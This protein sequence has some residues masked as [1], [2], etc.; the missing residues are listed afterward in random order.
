[1]AEPPQTAFSDNKREITEN[2]SWIQLQLRHQPRVSTSTL[3]P[4]VSIPTPTPFQLNSN[5]NPEASTPTPTPGIGVGVESTPTP[6]PES[7]PTLKFSFICTWNS[8]KPSAG[9]NQCIASAN[10]QPI[11][12]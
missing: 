2:K 4:E 9:C 12:P 3:T 7:A 10:E 6:T 5:Q 11:A 8:M 1:M